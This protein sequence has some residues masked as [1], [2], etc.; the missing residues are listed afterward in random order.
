MARKKTVQEIV[1]QEMPNFRVLEPNPAAE[2]RPLA[3]ADATS[4]DLDALRRK[5]LGV[6]AAAS[7]TRTLD[8]DEAAGPEDDTEIVLTVPRNADALN[9]G[10][11]PK[12]AVV[13]KSKGKVIGSQ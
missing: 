10:A 5:F 2:P 4:P 3:S 8:A 7:S 1:E 11:G 12:A 13:S 9:R 6:D